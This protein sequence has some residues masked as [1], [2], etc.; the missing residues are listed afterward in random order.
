MW[1]NMTVNELEK[2]H[3]GYF[4][5]KKMSFNKMESIKQSIFDPY[6]TDS[7]L[8]TVQIVGKHFK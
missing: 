4:S 8:I 2:K 7:S 3:S 5:G 1:L 6:Q